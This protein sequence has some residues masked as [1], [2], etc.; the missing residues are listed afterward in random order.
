MRTPP[1]FESN[2]CS[3]CTHDIQTT[4]RR[5]PATC[6]YN[7]RNSLMRTVCFCL[8]TLISLPSFAADWR[9]PESQLAQKIAAVTGP[10]V[11]ALDLINRSSIS[12]PEAEQIHRGLVSRLA[13]AGVRV[14][15]PE[16]AAATVQLT[17]SENL[18]NYVWVAEIQQAANE[19]SIVIVSAPRPDSAT[20]SQLAF[21][22]TI[23]AMPLVSQPEPILDAA[24][25]EG[26]PRRMVTL[27]Q[28]AVTVWVE[29]D[30]KWTAS[31]P[32]A[33]QHADAFPRDPRGRIILGNDHLFDIYL[34]G[35]IC[36]SVSSFPISMSC[37]RNDDPWPIAGANSGITGFFAPSRNFFTGALV[38]GVGKQKSAPPFYSAASIPRDNYTLWLFTGVDG[39]LHMLDGINQQVA[40]K[41]HWG[42]DIAGLHPTCRPGSQ[43]LATSTGSSSEDSVQ[44]YDFPGREPLAVTEKLT[45]AGP[46]TA[47]WPSQDGQSATAVYRNS[48]TGNYE[49]LLLTLTC[50]Q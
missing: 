40:A 22:M 30:S 46:V 17:L 19:N 1:I 44:A 21:P 5:A 20:N 11:I 49:A 8:L 47:L 12:A 32:L 10:C 26:S 33:I 50:A 31:E 27:S 23:R 36:H 37:A 3:G 9:Q 38:P 34:P 25:V 2:E 6:I 24:V 18:Q 7:S 45:L 14:W 4:G 41:V 28:H 15:A 13:A 35:Y 48:G 29:N 42:S 16:Q 39:Q 43:V